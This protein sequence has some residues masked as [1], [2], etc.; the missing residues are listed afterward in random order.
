MRTLSPAEK[1]DAWVEYGA[2]RYRE[3]FLRLFRE[4]VKDGRVPGVDPADADDTLRFFEETPEEYW[5]AL[6]AQ[7]PRAFKRQIDEFARLTAQAGGV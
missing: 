3:T 4:E 7:S 2:R 5:R 6:A 1:H